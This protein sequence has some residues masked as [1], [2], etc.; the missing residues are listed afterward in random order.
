M[1]PPHDFA[2]LEY[3][4]SRSLPLEHILVALVTYATGPLFPTFTPSQHACL[5]QA[6]REIAMALQS[7]LDGNDASQEGAS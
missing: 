5:T 2:G 4:L 3:A 1:T 7:I 6:R